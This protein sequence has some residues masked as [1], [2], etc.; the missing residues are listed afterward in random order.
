MVPNL[1]IFYFLSR[2]FAI[3]QI[4]RVDFNITI[5]FS[6]ISPKYPNKAFLVP[7]LGIFVFFTNDFWFCDR[8]RNRTNSRKQTSC[9]RIVFSKFTPKICKSDIF[10]H[11]FKDYYFAPNIAIRQIRGRWFQIWQSFFSN[12]SLK[13]AK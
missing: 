5:L 4:R 3:R 12:S 10:G 13:I 1:G 9:R 11:K 8:L 6:N 7:N 2:N